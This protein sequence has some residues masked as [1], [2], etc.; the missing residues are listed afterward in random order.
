MLLSMR[1]AS[2]SGLVLR[3]CLGSALML[4]FGDGAESR[5]EWR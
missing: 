5:V 4:E 2:H 1:G 3:I